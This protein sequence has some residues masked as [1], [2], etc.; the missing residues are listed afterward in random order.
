MRARIECAASATLINL[1]NCFVTQRGRE[2]LGEGTTI[3]VIVSPD[4]FSFVEI[5][6]ETARLVV[7]CVSDKEFFHG[8]GKVYRSIY[9]VYIYIYIYDIRISVFRFDKNKSRSKGAGKF[10]SIHHR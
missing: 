2:P 5:D 8:F 10:I 7:A 6:D 9:Y 4:A 3:D 1:K